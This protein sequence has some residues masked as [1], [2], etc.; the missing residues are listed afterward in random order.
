MSTD[1]ISR[2]VKTRQPKANN[3]AA[4][5]QR[6]G[7]FYAPIRA[8]TRTDPG[9]TYLFFHLFDDIITHP[10]QGEAPI[11]EEILHSHHAGQVGE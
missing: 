6:I 3:K 9:R 1:G 7:G 4:N 11:M 10:C 2:T 5:A 8:G